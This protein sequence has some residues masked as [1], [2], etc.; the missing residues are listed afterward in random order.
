[1][2]RAD[3]KEHVLMEVAHMWATLST[4]SSRSAVGCVLVDPS[5]RIVASGYNGSPRGLPHCDDVGCKFDSSGHCVRVVHAELNAILQCAITG[6]SCEG[7]TL[8]STHSPCI[9]CA[10]LL[11]QAGIKKVIYEQEYGKLDDVI[12]VN[13]LLL[14]AGVS[15]RSINA[16]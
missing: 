11:I 8:Y 4:C 15:V 2:S 14:S 7:T 9:R 1:M 6:V 10:V 3:I 12:A 5:G 16:S 13:N